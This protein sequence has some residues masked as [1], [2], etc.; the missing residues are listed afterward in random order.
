[1]VSIICKNSFIKD[2]GAIHR[3]IFLQTKTLVEIERRSCYA[4]GFSNCSS[5]P[6]EISFHGQI[7]YS[8]RKQIV[9]IIAVDSILLLRNSHLQ[10]DILANIF[11]PVCSW[12]F[13][14]LM[15]RIKKNVPKIFR[16]FTRKTSF[17]RNSQWRC[18][19]KE[20]FIEILQNL[21][22]NT[23]ARDSILIKL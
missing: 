22:K 14:K 19:V 21:Q 4:N 12:T 7:P 13:R 18:F 1:M 16:K 23:C 8:I 5:T 6:S 15:Q 20:L 17:Y 10:G 11:S 3:F 9:V 2:V